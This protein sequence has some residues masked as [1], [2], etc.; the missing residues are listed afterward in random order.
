MFWSKSEKH[1]AAIFMLC[2]DGR[3]HPDAACNIVSVTRDSFA[4]AALGLPGGD[5]Q[6][7]QADEYGRPTCVRVTSRPPRRRLLLPCL[8]AAGR[9]AISRVLV[10]FLP[11]VPGVCSNVSKENFGERILQTTSMDLHYLYCLCHWLN[12]LQNAKVWFLAPIGFNF[13][14]R[15][16]FFRE[17]RRCWLKRH[18]GVWQ[19][20][21]G[22]GGKDLDSLKT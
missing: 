7:S 18:C 2:Y 8:P 14:A 6:T 22:K 16:F 11:G 9:H 17:Q 3:H 12:T 10:I 4:G 15:W 13:A 20:C 5:K 21:R 19:D 1:L